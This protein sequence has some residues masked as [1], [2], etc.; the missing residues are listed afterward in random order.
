[1]RSS[2]SIWFGSICLFVLALVGLRFEILYE[3]S[4]ATQIAPND[5]VTLV[6]VDP[7][8]LPFIGPDAA[9]TTSSFAVS[10]LRV[11]RDTLNYDDTIYHSLK[12]NKIGE[13]QILNLNQALKNVLDTRSESKP[14]DHYILKV[15][16]SGTIQHFSYTPEK[17]PE[18]PILIVRQAGRL[19]A[20]RLQ[21]PLETRLETI[22]VSIVDNLFNAISIAGENDA[23]TD[24]LTD[25]IFGAVIDFIVD[26]RVGDRMGIVFEKIYQNGRFIRYGR[27]LL[28]HYQGRVV[29]QLAVYYENPAKTWGYYDAKGQSVARP[30][31]L[32]PLSYRRISS[33]FS[34][35]RFHP[36]LKKN[37][38]HLGVDYAASS[39]T[40]VWATARGRVTYAGRKGSY[41]KLVEIEH[42]NGYRTRYAHLSRIRVKKGQ[43]IKQ[44]TVVGNVGMTGRATGPHLHY[45]LLKNGHHINPRNINRQAEGE[46]LQ[47]RYLQDF[48]RQRDAHLALLR[49]PTT[50]EIQLVDR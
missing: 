3:R 46:P 42:A 18:R 33:P 35:K 1:M 9:E 20:Q 17:T 16:T 45:E 47:K 5:E 14:G 15:D 13:A 27:I 41:G 2:S 49:R 40:K 12:R 39:G 4:A 43:S 30:F 11:I 34:R 29:E 50:P 24:R 28:A 25:D 36:V 26:P 10:A 44:H 7:V 38:P 8:Q 6:A 32:Q 19:S 22:E 31:L 37:V 48:A 23:L 21:L